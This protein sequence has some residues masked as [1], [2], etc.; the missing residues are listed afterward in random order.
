M[1]LQLLQHCGWDMIGYIPEFLVENDPR[2]A[3]EQFNERYAHGGGWQPFQGFTR[4]E[5]TNVIKYPGDPPIAPVAKIIFRQ[6]QIFIYPHAWVSIVQSDG[7]WEICRM[8]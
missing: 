7:S 4:N 6:E 1:E 5:D 8:D 3:A 2:P